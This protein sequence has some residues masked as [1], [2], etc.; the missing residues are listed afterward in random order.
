VVG[1]IKDGVDKKGKSDMT[2]SYIEDYCPD[3]DELTTFQEFASFTGTYRRC[4]TCGYQ[5]SV[6]T[7]IEDFEIPTPWEIINGKDEDEEW[8]I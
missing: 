5:V 2:V 4:M 6:M 1:R 8:D 3:C 7:D